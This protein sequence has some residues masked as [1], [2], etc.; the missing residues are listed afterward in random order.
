MTQIKIFDEG[1]SAVDIKQGS[2]GDCYLLSAMSV[3]AHSRPELI[4]KVFHQSARQYNDSGLYT[5]MFFRNRKPCIITVDDHFPTK[6]VRL[7]PF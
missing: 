1:I 3:I 6:N 7:I 4:Q 2:L 5:L